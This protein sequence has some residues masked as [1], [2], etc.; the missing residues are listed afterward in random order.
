MS[1]VSVF[2][3]SSV[4]N[5][6]LLQSVN[7]APH[8]QVNL[9]DTCTLHRCDLWTE[10]STQMCVVW[11]GVSVCQCVWGWW[12]S[13]R[14]RRR[15][16]EEEGV[17]PVRRYKSRCQP[18]SE[19]QVTQ[20]KPPTHRCCRCVHRHHRSVREATRA[21]RLSNYLVKDKVCVC[22]WCT[23]SCR[24]LFWWSRT[25][26]SSSSALLTPFILLLLFTTLIWRFTFS[27]IYFL[28]E[29]S[30]FQNLFTLYLLLYRS[31]CIEGVILFW[32]SNTWRS[33]PAFALLV[34]LL[35]LFVCI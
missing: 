33:P 31:F 13:R 23:S 29:Q 10:G 27:E 17:L 15:G 7:T 35:L 8:M 4:N 21:R 1:Q 34:D 24:F 28:V 2:F 9:T 22:V 30:L 19:Q 25:V 3:P 18:G 12:W 16:V 20:V 11:C 32:K 6:H 26:I 5:L 14:R